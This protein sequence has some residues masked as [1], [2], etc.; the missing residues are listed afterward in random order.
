MRGEVQQGQG[1]GDAL[2]LRMEKSQ[3]KEEREIG[4]QV[5]GDVHKEPGPR[6][7]GSG[8]QAVSRL[9]VSGSEFLR[10]QGWVGVGWDSP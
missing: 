7:P 10:K 2:D 5:G 1:S 3:R 9:R 8:S 6:S 4:M